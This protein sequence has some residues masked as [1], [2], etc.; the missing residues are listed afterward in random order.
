M[1]AFAVKGDHDRTTAILETA[2]KIRKSQF[3]IDGEAVLSRGGGISNFTALHSRKRTTTSS[4]AF[5]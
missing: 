4:S 3:I 2:L 5:D 1:T